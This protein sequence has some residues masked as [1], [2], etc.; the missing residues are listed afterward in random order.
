MA[1]RIDVYDMATPMAMVQ[2]RR[3]ANLATKAG[4]LMRITGIA[5][6]GY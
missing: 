1:A 6:R 2:D 4:E 5:I 3:Y